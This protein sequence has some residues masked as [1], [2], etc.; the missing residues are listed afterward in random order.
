[1]S[2]SITKGLTKL[3]GSLYID[4]NNGDVF[5]IHSTWFKQPMGNIKD[6]DAFDIF[7]NSFG[8]KDGKKIRKALAVSIMKSVKFE[9]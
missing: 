8:T 1:M 6:T 3:D 4:K 7:T 9:M 5:M 2:Q